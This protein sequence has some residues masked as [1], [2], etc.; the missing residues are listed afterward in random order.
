MG[1]CR[2]C[3]HSFNRPIPNTVGDAP[4]SSNADISPFLQLPTQYSRLS[5]GALDPPRSQYRFQTM[6]PA[7]CHFHT[8]PIFRRMVLPPLIPRYLRP[9]RKVLP[10]PTLLLLIRWMSISRPVPHYPF[11]LSRFVL[12]FSE[13][14]LLRIQ[15]R[16]VTPTAS[17]VATVTAP[18]ADILHPLSVYWVGRQAR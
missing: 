9:W 6:H 12:P 4:K 13:Y 14:R 2:F 3:T 18:G 7:H 16:P 5:E 17:L 10:L 11:L 8:P 1:I 15:V